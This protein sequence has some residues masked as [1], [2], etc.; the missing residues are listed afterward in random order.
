MKNKHLNKLRGIIISLA[1]IFILLAIFMRCK[2]EKG[3]ESSTTILNLKFE[4]GVNLSSS[5]YKNIY[6]V[7]IE[8]TSSSYIQNLY[9]CKKLVNGGLTGTALPYWKSNVY[10][11]LSESDIDAVTGATNANSDFTISTGLEDTAVKKFTIYFEIDR[12]FDANDWFTDQPA[13]LY[14]AIVNLDSAKEYNLTPV[15]WTP[16]EN[17]ANVISNTPMGQL[18]KEM[19]YITNHK[20]NDTFGDSDTLSATSMVKKI[21][22]TVN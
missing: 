4:Y 13:L 8:D 7:W 5:A 2:N 16:N 11:K 1:G 12:S 17:T 9:I 20:T 10:P 15:G 19:R 6:V 14:S 3:K 22:L 21:T 18:Q